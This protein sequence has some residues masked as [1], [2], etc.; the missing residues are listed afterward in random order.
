MS[1]LY[2]FLLSLLSTVLKARVFVSLWNWF[3]YPGIFDFRL[4]LIH[5]FGLI[6]L[7][8]LFNTFTLSDIEETLK[9][10]DEDKCRLILNYVVVYLYVWLIGWLCFYFM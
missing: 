5:A 7:F 4:G 9:M 6:H 3:L 8:F 10:T 2:I 1:K